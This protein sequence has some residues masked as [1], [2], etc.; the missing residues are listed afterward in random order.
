MSELV[1]S[2]SRTWTPPP[3]PPLPSLR[4]GGWGAEPVAAW[5][6]TMLLRIVILGFRGDSCWDVVIM[7]ERISWESVDVDPVSISHYVWGV[8]KSDIL[9][10]ISPNSFDFPVA[11][12][13]SCKK[14]GLH[15][16]GHDCFLG[17][18]HHTYRDLLS[19]RG[20]LSPHYVRNW[21]RNREHDNLHYWA[22]PSAIMARVGETS[23]ANGFF[24]L[25][26]TSEAA[27]N[28]WIARIQLCE[29]RW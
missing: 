27:D 5:A 24:L 6:S 16:L 26:A 14:D 28:P 9:K 8:G 10:F 3:P 15:L 22:A 25:I 2:I 21:F 7:T 18:R 17:H 12:W 23:F 29:R 19:G 20:L 11:G 13:G 4:I 1:S